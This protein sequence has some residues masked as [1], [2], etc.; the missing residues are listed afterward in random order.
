MRK[1]VTTRP[2]ARRARLA[3]LTGILAFIPVAWSAPEGI[4]AN[5]ACAGSGC[6]FNPSAICE[7]D[8]SDH[9]GYENKTWGQII[10][11]C[12]D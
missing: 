6:C 1:I 2:L 5:E 4:G 3:A 11:G 10:F 7:T 8:H 9:A 12:P